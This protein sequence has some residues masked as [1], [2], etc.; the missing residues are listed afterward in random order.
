MKLLPG[1][2]CKA[3]WYGCCKMCN[4]RAIIIV[5]IITMRVSLLAL[6]L[7]QSSCSS[8][9]PSWQ[10]FTPSHT[11]ESSKHTVPLSHLLESHFGL[12]AQ[13]T[14]MVKRGKQNLYNGFK[15]VPCGINSNTN[16]FRCQVDFV[17][18]SEIET[19]NSNMF[20]HARFKHTTNKSCINSSSKRYYDLKFF[21]KSSYYSV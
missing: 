19:W 6:M 4:V 18:E 15:S 20:T 1:N 12:T 9:D 17:Y 13:I 3:H 14:K 21:V 16:L 5:V 10:S 11:W 7:S 8:S 2:W